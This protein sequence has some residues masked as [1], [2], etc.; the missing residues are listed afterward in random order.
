[1]AGFTEVSIFGGP[2][3]TTPR[4]LAFHSLDLSRSER[5][6]T[7][8]V[9]CN[10]TL[11]HWQGSITTPCCSNTHC[12]PLRCS[13]WTTLLSRE[14]WVLRKCLRGNSTIKTFFS[15]LKVGEVALWLQWQIKRMNLRISY[16]KLKKK[17]TPPKQN[18]SHIT[19]VTCIFGELWL[20]LF[21]KYHH[22]MAINYNI[23]CS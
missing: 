9:L 18:P 4:C 22:G 23:I 20:K 3:A 21:T 5:L 6:M 17:K 19:F 1:M 7:G 10:Y 11:S 12:A 16:E 14:R 2:V 15:Q 13:G 8:S